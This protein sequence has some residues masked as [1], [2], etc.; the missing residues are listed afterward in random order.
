M[1]CK[2]NHSQP[3][4]STSRKEVTTQRE[5]AETDLWGTW[6]MCEAI[7]KENGAAY[8]LSISSVVDEGALE[9]YNR[10]VIIFDEMEAVIDAELV[11]SSEVAG[12][13]FYTC[14]SNC[15]EIEE[16]V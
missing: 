11:L 9:M 8:P 14:T 5:G 7:L 13:D 10:I 12:E 6:K 16:E 2:I 4:T 3:S 1:K 15:E